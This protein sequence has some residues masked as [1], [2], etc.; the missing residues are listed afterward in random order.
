MVDNV[1]VNGHGPYRFIV[2]TGTNVN[3]IDSALARA[4]D[5]KAAFR[6]ELIS[7][8]GASALPGSDTNEISLGSVH[9]DKQQFL[10]TDLRE[11]RQNFPEVKGVLGQLFLGRFDYRIDLRGKRLQF[12]TQNPTGKRTTFTVRS[13]R[14]SVTTSLGDLVLD[15]GTDRL[16]LFGVE[17]GRDSGDYYK[18]VTGSRFVGTVSSNLAIEGRSLWHGDA[19]ALPNRAEPGVAGLMPVSLFRAVYVSNS[20]GFVVFE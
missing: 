3:L 15:S 8:V 7:A 9:A 14:T 6:V 19:V 20:E 10:F 5:M 4:I 18:S 16:V 13:G 12:G 11:M 1:F 2:D 17:P